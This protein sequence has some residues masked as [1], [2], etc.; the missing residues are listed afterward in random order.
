MPFMRKGRL[1]RARGLIK[2]I[3]VTAAVAAGL[4]IAIPATP[5]AAAISSVD[6][7]SPVIQEYVRIET[8]Y[9]PGPT[10]LANAGSK[11][12]HLL[13]ATDFHSGNNKVTFF[14]TVNEN[15][16]QTSLTLEK[17]KD[18]GLAFGFHATVTSVVIW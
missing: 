2:E 13:L 3:T 4:T 9:L 16:Y 10:C 8:D 11:N 18:R 5:A 14:Y 17:W 6:C 15:N 7:G 12:M 1:V